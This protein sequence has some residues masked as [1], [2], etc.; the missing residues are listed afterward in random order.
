MIIDL[1]SCLS[2]SATRAASLIG[3]LC[4]FSSAGFAGS[5][6]YTSTFSD[7]NNVGSV[8]GGLLNPSKSDI[9]IN[10]GPWD[11]TFQG[12][13]GV[14]APPSLQISTTGGY[15]G[16]SATVDGIAGVQVLGNTVNNPGWFYTDTGV[17]YQANTQ[18][19]LSVD[20]NVGGLLNNLSVL[21]NAGVGIGLTQGGDNLFAATTNP[22]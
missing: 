17:A 16:G 21:S 9:A 5:V 12:I 6:L 1:Q 3:L 11:G 22:D 15:T 2:K 13:L 14:L 19:T 7:P 10:K 4:L 20:V 18:Y 8:G